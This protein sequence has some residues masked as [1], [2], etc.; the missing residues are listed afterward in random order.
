MPP[1]L[2]LLEELELELDELLVDE[3]LEVELVVDELLEEVELTPLDDA[4]GPPPAPPPELELDAFATPPWP[5]ELEDVAVPP[6]PDAPPDDAKRTPPLVPQPS[7]TPPSNAKQDQASVRIGGIVRGD[8]PSDNAVGRGAHAI[9]A[10]GCA[11]RALEITGR[12]AYEALPI[13]ARTGE[14]AQ[15]RA[16]QR[17]VAGAPRAC[18][19]R[20]L[21]SRRLRTGF[22]EG[23]RRPRGGGRPTREDRRGDRPRSDPR[24]R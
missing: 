12:A 1:E 11:T 2:E 14:H 5:L 17:A 4:L 13:R 10:R 16:R 19:P 24:A 21:R 8:R 15:R 3:L 18:A 9:G 6:V 23:A 20:M 7:S 22:G